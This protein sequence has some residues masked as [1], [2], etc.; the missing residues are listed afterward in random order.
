MANI[1]NLQQQIDDL[2]R[3]PKIVEEFKKEVAQ[4]KLSELYEQTYDRKYHIGENGDPYKAGTE[5]NKL[6]KSVTQDEIKE[7]ARER[8]QQNIDLDDSYK[9][10]GITR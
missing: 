3:D 2:L 6:Y 9:A 10:R 7:H 1:R 4:K 5:I 8:A